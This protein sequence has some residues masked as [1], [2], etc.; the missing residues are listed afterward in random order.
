MAAI[1]CGV[2][3]SA[4]AR[5]AARLSATLARRLG[6]ELV[7]EHA[8]PR[9]GDRVDA[10]TMLEE[11][12][13]E[14]DV[15]TARLRVDVGPAAERLTTASQGAALVVVGGANG[16]ADRMTFGGTVRAALARHARC[17]VVVVPAVPRL[18]GSEV[19]CGVRDWADVTTAAVANRLASALGLPLLLMHVLPPAAGRGEAPSGPPLV[20]F[21]RPWDHETA[22][23]LLDLVA[24]AVGG[25]PSLRVEPGSAGR[26]L[27]QEATAREA[28]LLVVGPPARGRLGAALTG[29]VSTHLMRRSQRPL[30]ICCGASV[31]G[32]P[33][34]C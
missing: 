18:G 28:G 23:R 6:V 2:D 20:A 27:A 30:V 8:L 3:G 34:A 31:P 19:I 7:L 21:E 32:L 1:V 26:R 29:S 12:R 13:R 11:L 24:D 9:A 5:A 10:L 17:P 16:Q 15:P 4:P 33:R 14:L 25:T 22:Y